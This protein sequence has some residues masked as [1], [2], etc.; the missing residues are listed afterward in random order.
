MTLA[1]A[2]ANFTR[3][4]RA[5]A[6]S[7]ANKGRATR[8][9]EVTGQKPNAPPNCVAIVVPSTT[10]VQAATRVTRLW[11]DNGARDVVLYDRSGV[12]AASVAEIYHALDGDASV[13]AGWRREMPASSSGDH[14]RVCVASHADRGAIAACR[15]SGADAAGPEEADELLRASLARYAVANGGSPALARVVPQLVAVYGVKT[16]TLDGLPPWLASSAE[17]SSVNDWG[18]R[19]VHRAIEAYMSAHIRRGR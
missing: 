13:C 4:Y 15:A 7:I 3:T 8:Q 12:L 9:V 11:I 6:A 1:I 5:I 14:V 2:A 18:K 19:G 10:D 16:L 17:I